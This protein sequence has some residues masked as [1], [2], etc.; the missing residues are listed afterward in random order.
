VDVVRQGRQVE[1]VRLPDPIGNVVGFDSVSADRI[2]QAFGDFTEDKKFSGSEL[3]HILK[4]YGV[5]PGDRV[6]EIGSIH[7]FQ[8]I[9]MGAVLRG[10]FVVL[11]DLSEG[12]GVLIGLFDRWNAKLRDG[13]V[14]A[15]A[16]VELEE[17]KVIGGLIASADLQVYPNPNQGIFKVSIDANEKTS[18]VKSISISPSSLSELLFEV[19]SGIL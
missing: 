6:L 3:A 10:E 12:K 7:P 18:T 1:D 19:T 11:E 2:S 17:V 5:K 8:D 14:E 4:S 13:L 15:M 16:G 9:K